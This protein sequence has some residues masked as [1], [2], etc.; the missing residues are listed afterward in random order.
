[1]P[2]HRGGR[3]GLLSAL[4]GD[5]SRRAVEVIQPWP[6]GCGSF[7]ASALAGGSLSEADACKPR[8]PAVGASARRTRPRMPSVDDQ[9]ELI[10]SE[11][12]SVS[13]RSS[14]SSSAPPANGRRRR[15]STTAIPSPSSSSSSV[16]AGRPRRLRRRDPLGPRAEARILDPCRAGRR[17]RAVDCCERSRIEDI[18]NPPRRHATGRRS[19][20][21]ASPHRRA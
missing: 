10:V 1:V 17:H 3:R 6:H 16:E 2:P 13:S 4:T 8:L 21:P 7:R 12:S 11:P 19:E 5:A 15:P 20:G 18:E 9:Q 14:P